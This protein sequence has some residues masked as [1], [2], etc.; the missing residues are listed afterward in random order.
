VLE[1]SEVSVC[2]SVDDDAPSDVYL[3][4][5]DEDEAVE[6]V[7][8]DCLVSLLET[9]NAERAVVMLVVVS[10]IIEDTDCVETESLVLDE[11]IVVAENEEIPESDVGGWVVKPA[12][13]VLRSLVPVLMPELELDRSTV[14]IEE[15][16]YTVFIVAEAMLDP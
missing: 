8:L 7:S 13:C 11:V 2:S 14:I 9:G 16:V 15:I 5:D 12:D 3:D 6:I 10:T 4:L 1:V